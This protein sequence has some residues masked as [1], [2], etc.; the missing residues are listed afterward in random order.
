MAGE[1]FVDEL[2]GFLEQHRGKAIKFEEDKNFGRM[3]D[4]SL[5]DFEVR[6][7]ALLLPNL[8]LCFPEPD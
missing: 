3:C 5:N 6:G 7:D 1:L 8:C 4:V 2:I